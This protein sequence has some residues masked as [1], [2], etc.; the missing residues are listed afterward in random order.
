MQENKIRFANGELRTGIHKANKFW[1]AMEEH[2]RFLE[3]NEAPNIGLRY[4]KLF[5]WDQLIDAK[6]G[7]PAPMIDLEDPNTTEEDKVIDI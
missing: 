3:R 2:Q 7:V 1:P 5:S 4:E 6:P